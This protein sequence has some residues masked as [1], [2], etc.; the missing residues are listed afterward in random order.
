MDRHLFV[1]VLWLLAGVIVTPAF[2]TAAH[3]SPATIWTQRNDNARSGQNNN[4]TELNVGNVNKNTFG[5]LFS[6]PVDD[7]VYTQPLYIPALTMSADNK[8]H[9]V[10]FVGTVNNTLYAFDADDPKAN[11]GKPLWSRN[12][13]PAGA[14]P[15]TA[16]D[17]AW[18]YRDFA[19]NM[20]IV[21]TP[22]IDTDSRTL[23]V[24]SRHVAG[25][26]F[27]QQ[28]HAV[29]IRTGQ[30]RPNS[31]VVITAAY[32]AAGVTTKFDSLYQN[33][34]A[35][36]TLVN[37]VVYIAW[38]SHGDI[39]DYH[40]WIMGYRASDLKQTTVWNT[41]P[42]GS[43]S[44]IW[45]A[46]E[47]LTT[48]DA[49]NIYCMTGNGAF[50][51][52]DNFGE[53]VLKLSANPATGALSVLDYFAPA[54]W[55]MLNATDNDLGSS[56]VMVIPGT[57]LLLGGG[58]GGALY[59]ID[60]DNMGKEND[61]NNIVQE[62]QG[63][64]PVGGQSG[65][66]H[67]SPIYWK[68]ASGQ[69]VYVWGEND[70]L[71]QYKFTNGADA[72]HGSFNTSATSHS[73]FRAP[74]FYRGMPGGFLSVTSNNAAPGTG[75]L[76]ASTPFN[77]NA[78]QKVVEGSLS[79][80]DARDVSHVLWTSKDFPSRDDIG[81]FA[82]FVCPTVTN[83]KMYMPSW[84]VHGGP[85]QL[86]V[87]GLIPAPTAGT[88]L[89]VQYFNDPAN[90]KYPLT[91]PFAGSPILTRIDPVIDFDW[92]RTSPDPIVRT[93]HF[94]ARWTGQIEPRYSENYTL[95]LQSSN[96]RRLWVNGRLLIDKWIDNRDTD[97]TGQI[98][99]EA[100]KKYDIRLEYFANVGMADAKLSW[101]SA[102]Q[103]LESVPQSQLYPV[104]YTPPKR[105]VLPKTQHAVPKRPSLVK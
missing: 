58:K 42:S 61:A 22:V 6:Y 82:K 14:R 30:E 75:I 100:G 3:A 16:S 88:G 48:D 86:C 73:P 26:N 28:L 54:N 66:I 10:V 21:G 105:A 12:L 40:G 23:Y 38:A 79:A 78:N 2:H 103:A 87:Y 27:A 96:G 56:G 52:K 44:S 64:A 89:A 74:V 97:Y 33:Q 4:E 31:P 101:Q 29:D 71:R 8:P 98:A 18:D 39:G 47:G 91:K 17:I 34:R 41:T 11:G 57:K 25:D 36:L 9:N 77:D 51:G 20:G 35:A 69:F 49:G 99:L 5:K 93:N 72:N 67:G 45:Q 37:G 95:H 102:S 43:M 55:E 63:T 32:T 80:F 81:L 60:S 76:W 68:D 65:H 94:S 24:V 84:G 15:P 13:T 92:G 70:Y 83:G 90:G 104:P 62:F 85:C 50:D 59:L 46:G 19:K 7:Q 1:R 53:C